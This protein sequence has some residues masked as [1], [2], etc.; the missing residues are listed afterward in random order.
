MATLLLPEIFF[1][2][3]INTAMFTFKYCWNWFT[4]DVIWIAAFEELIPFDLFHEDTLAV[5]KAQMQ[6][7][8]KEVEQILHWH[9]VSLI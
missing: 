2:K 9:Q 3:S 1:G 5:M 6:K 4:H 7:D 8:L